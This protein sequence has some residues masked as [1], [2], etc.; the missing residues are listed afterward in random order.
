MKKILITGVNGFIGTHLMEAL[1][2]D[3]RWDIQGFDLMSDNLRPFIGCPNFKFTT[4]DIFKDGKWLEEQV[5]SSD[6]VLPLAGIA[7]PAYYLQKPI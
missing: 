1:C 5:E 7:K 3:N 6:I 4:G 2:K